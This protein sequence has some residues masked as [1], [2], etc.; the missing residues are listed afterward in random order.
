MKGKA[1]LLAQEMNIAKRIQTSL[2]PKSP[3]HLDLEIAAV[4]IPADEVGGDFYDIS[5]DK[6]GNLWIGIGDVSGHGVT[7]GLIM[8]MTQTIF[9]VFQKNISQESITPSKLIVTI[10]EVL[11]ENVQNRLDENHFM[12][13]T[14]FKYLGNGDFSYSGAHLDL[15]FH[16]AKTDA[17][18]TFSTS[19]LFMNIIPDVSEISQDGH[20]NLN[21]GDTLILYTDGIPEAKNC[22]N[23]GILNQLLDYERF[24]DIIKKHIHKDV[25]GVKEGIIKETI[26]W[27]HNVRADDMTLIVIR[28]K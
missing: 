2:L 26:S 28:R 8:M 6:A 20:F 13:L 11:I 21:S 22:Q 9:T 15:I 25:D 5:Y 18:E 3:R 17:I 10:N 16:R 19:G 7:P 14:I 1:R 4:M 23:T 27:C 24:M 12:T